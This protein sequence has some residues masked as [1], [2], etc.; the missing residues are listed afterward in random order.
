MKVDQKRDSKISGSRDWTKNS[1]PE[2]LTFVGLE[3]DQKLDPKLEQKLYLAT[4]DSLEKSYNLIV[5]TI[6]IYWLIIS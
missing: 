2:I 4:P 5:S 3:L 6:Y 1:D